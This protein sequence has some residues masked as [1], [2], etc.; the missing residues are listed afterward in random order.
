VHIAAKRT[1]NEWLFSVRDNGI[2]LDPQY[3]E[4]IFVIFQRLHGRGEYREQASVRH[5]PQDW[6][7]PRWAH[8]GQLTGRRSNLLPHIPDRSN[9]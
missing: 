7:A 5:L 6:G 2:G 4:R 3:A 1:G 9:A 8:L